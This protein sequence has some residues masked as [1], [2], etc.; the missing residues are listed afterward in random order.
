MK[1]ACCESPLV[2]SYKYRS[3]SFKYRRDSFKSDQA[4]P[5]DR[6]E[7][8]CFRVCRQ[9][10]RRPDGARRRRILLCALLLC[11]HTRHRTHARAMVD[12]SRGGLRRM[13][14]SSSS[15]SRPFASCAGGWCDDDDDDDDDD[16]VTG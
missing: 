1:M 2:Y 11:A 6:G 10:P 12:R 9:R 8:P 3:D 16:G 7:A 5:G 13:S 14:S 15:S 4:T